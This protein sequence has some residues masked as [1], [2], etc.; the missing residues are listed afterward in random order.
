MMLSVAPNSTEALIR[1]LEARVAALEK[2]LQVSA[3]QVVLQSGAAKIV[4]TH[5]GD[6]Q[7]TANRT[8]LTSAG[9]AQIKAGGNLILKAAR[10][11]QS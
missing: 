2:A 6:V 1:A 8:T 9:D 5:T 4:L 10:I 3:S 11:T 7:I